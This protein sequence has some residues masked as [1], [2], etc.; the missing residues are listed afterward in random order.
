MFIISENYIRKIK[1]L[2]FLTFEELSTET[3][4]S[5]NI[6]EFPEQKN[7]KSTKTLKTFW[8]YV[9]KDCVFFHKLYD[10]NHIKVG[11]IKIQNTTK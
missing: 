7:L 5:I 3:E 4:F 8:E 1:S 2:I 9:V 6:S 10:R 11:K